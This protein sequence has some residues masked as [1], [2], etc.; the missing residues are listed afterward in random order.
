MTF[1]L[2]GQFPLILGGKQADSTD[3][4]QVHTYRVIQNLKAIRLGFPVRLF[5]FFFNLSIDR[6]LFLGAA[7]LLL[8]LA[9]FPLVILIFG[10]VHYHLYGGNRQTVTF[11]Q[12]V[13]FFL[14]YISEHS[15]TQELVLLLLFFV[16]IEVVFLGVDFPAGI[17][18][19][20][21]MSPS[22]KSV[23]G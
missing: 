3:F 9:V 4:P 16:D 15:Q 14:N 21:I 10:G 1:Q 8:D 6:P 22:T 18:S 17:A 13:L 7:R 19:Y 5:V 20:H 11:R 23:L 12:V 2:A